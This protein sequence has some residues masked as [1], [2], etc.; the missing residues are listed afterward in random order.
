MAFEILI[1]LILR[2]S[3]NSNDVKNMKKLHETKPP[4]KKVRSVCKR[5]LKK[6]ETSPIDYISPI[7]RKPFRE[8]LA[9]SDLFA[10]VETNSKSKQISI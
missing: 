10:G 1:D 4:S 6:R 9:K 2:N 8:E 5:P 7:D 3:S